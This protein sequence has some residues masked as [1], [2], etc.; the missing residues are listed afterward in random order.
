MLIGIERRSWSAAAVM[1]L[2]AMAGDADA[3]HAQVP[4]DS[5]VR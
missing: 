1:L 2:P 3:G 5:E 4:T